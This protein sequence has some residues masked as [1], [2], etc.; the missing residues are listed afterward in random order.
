[1][2][3]A[4]DGQLG[5]SVFTYQSGEVA[6]GQYGA[7]KHVLWRAV[8]FGQCGAKKHVIW[9]AVGQSGSKTLVTQR[10]KVGF[11]AAARRP[12]SPFPA[13]TPVKREG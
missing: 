3:A 2:V 13:L 4:S 8:A 5:R 10:A 11:C 7:E 12:T 1:M 9:R 6:F